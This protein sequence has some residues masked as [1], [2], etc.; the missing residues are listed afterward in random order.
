MSQIG[1]LLDE[2]LH[3]PARRLSLTRVSLLAGI[4]GFCALVLYVTFYWGSDYKPTQPAA[5]SDR[6]DFYL[7]TATSKTFNEEGQ[8][9][10]IT[11]SPRAEFF[12]KQQVGIFATPVMDIRR[13][14]GEQ[15]LI[16]AE[17]G[18][19]KEAE[20]QLTL[21]GNVN[22]SRTPSPMTIESEKMIAY[23]K[24]RKAETDLAVTIRTPEGILRAIGM[25][26]DLDA[27][28]IEFFENVRGQHDAP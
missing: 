10:S 7:N 25:Q 14:D 8:L 3:A 1:E 6:I 15:W 18:L 17:K 5:D 23:P 4:G 27:E 19:W 21:T 24:T 26:A 9:A 28:R 12:Q 13:A 2:E 20:E 11:T 16:K 22:A